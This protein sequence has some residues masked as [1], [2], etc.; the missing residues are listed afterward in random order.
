MT[1]TSFSKSR[2]MFEFG[3]EERFCRGDFAAGLRGLCRG[4]REAMSRSRIN[5]R[6]DSIYGGSGDL[7]SERT[8]S[9]GR[10]YKTVG[11]GARAEPNSDRMGGAGAV[12][13]T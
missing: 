10:P 11:L 3:F 4:F 9:E 5:L 13:G 12:H 6:N 8:A 2:P 7:T 1:A